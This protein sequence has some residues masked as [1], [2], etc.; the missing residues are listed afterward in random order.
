M[1]DRTNNW[2]NKVELAEKAKKHTREMLDKYSEE[3]VTAIADT[4][5]YDEQSKFTCSVD[6]ADT[7]IE[8][9]DTDS[10]TAAYRN[11]DSENLAVLNFA[12]YKH[13]GGMFVSGS[14]AQEECLCHASFLYNVLKFLMIL[15]MRGTADS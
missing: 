6:D 12:S 8:V 9:L 5:V 1:Y 4:K 3:I 2:S 11:R 10:V 13:P 15:S 14:K 7:V